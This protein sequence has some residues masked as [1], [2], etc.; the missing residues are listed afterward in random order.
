M[1][2]DIGSHVVRG[3]VSRASARPC[4]SWAT[5]QCPAEQARGVENH[6]EVERFFF[7]QNWPWAAFQTARTR[8][9]SRTDCQAHWYLSVQQPGSSSPRPFVKHGAL[10]PGRPPLRR[11][12]Q[13]SNG[14]ACKRRPPWNGDHRVKVPRGQQMSCTEWRKRR[15]PWEQ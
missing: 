2:R 1:R 14:T 5:Q 7:A 12:R 6:L 3:V 9:D 15:R 13:G 10:L 11:H 4:T 8:E